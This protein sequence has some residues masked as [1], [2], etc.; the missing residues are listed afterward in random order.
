MDGICIL[1]IASKLQQR[2]R[3]QLENRTLAI[4]L[5]MTKIAIRSIRPS[6]NNREKNQTKT[7]AYFV[8]FLARSLILA[9]AVKKSI[10]NSVG[11]KIAILFSSSSSPAGEY[12]AKM[13]R[14]SM[15]SGSMLASVNLFMNMRELGAE[16]V[17]THKIP[18][19][20][21]T[22]NTAYISFLLFFFIKCSKTFRCLPENR[23]IW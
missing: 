16:S 18:N 17:S 21:L 5:C 23:N 7:R 8:S 2:R 20:T 15:S 11:A 9:L 19:S 12:H 10:Q 13:E 22:R 6:T 1:R 14:I 3:T 4:W